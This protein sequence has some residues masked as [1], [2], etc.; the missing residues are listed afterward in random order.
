[1]LAV[2]LSWDVSLGTGA[3]RR[4]ARAPVFR[5]GPPPAAE[6]AIGRYGVAE[7]AEQER[8]RLDQALMARIAAGDQSAF[9]TVAAAETPRLLRFAFSLLPDSPAE[10]EEI[11]QE[12]LF[13]LWRQADGWRPRAKVAT[14]LHQ[15]VYRLA[16][17][18]LRRRRPSV[19]L[20]AL[21]SEAD[22]ETVAPEMRLIRI[23]NVN[24]VRV[25]VAALPERQRSALALCHFQ[26]LNQADAAAV[27]GIGER[28]YESLLARARRRLR[29]LLVENDAGS[30]NRGGR[31]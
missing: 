30:E 17:D 2:A 18:S 16:I 27:M 4:N 23:D 14:W 9:V 5:Y 3:P 21:E 29:E 7:G 25:A 13:R 31:S 26:E 11:V 10:A 24:A 19:E 1:M 6:G 12:A 20:D 22:E 28:A 15:V 8:I